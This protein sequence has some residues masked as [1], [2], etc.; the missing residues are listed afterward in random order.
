MKLDFT[1]S[2]PITVIVEEALKQSH[3]LGIAKGLR[4]A[5]DIAKQ[6]PYICHG[7]AAAAHCTEVV[8]EA[9]LAKAKEVEEGK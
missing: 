4:M 8:E 2:D 1:E 7:L 5:A 6:H 3:Q 9:I